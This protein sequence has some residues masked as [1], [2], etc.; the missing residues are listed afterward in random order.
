MVVSMFG[1]RRGVLLWTEE[2]KQKDSLV[3]K[4]QLKAGWFQDLDDFERNDGNFTTELRLAKPFFSHLFKLVHMCH[5]ERTD[6]FIS[7][8][9]F[10]ELKYC[11][12]YDVQPY[13]T[14]PSL[15]LTGFGDDCITKTV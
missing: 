2:D 3:P 5:R 12:R 15:S 6:K 8:C 7:R 14:F 13:A 9:K 4:V 10:L 1:L 11:H